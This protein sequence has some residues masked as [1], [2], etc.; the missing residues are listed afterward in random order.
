MPHINPHVLLNIL[1]KHL[2]EL[3]DIYTES[4]NNSISDKLLRQIEKLRLVIM[5]LEDTYVF[6]QNMIE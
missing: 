6:E 4:V 1:K 3:Y 5:K 2:E